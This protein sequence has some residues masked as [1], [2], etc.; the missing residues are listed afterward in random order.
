MCESNVV[1]LFYKAELIVQFETLT[2]LIEVMIARHCLK[3]LYYSY[4][5]KKMLLWKIKGHYLKKYFEHTCHLKYGKI[6][7]IKAKV[8]W[9]LEITSFLFLSLFYQEKHGKYLN[10]HRDKARFFAI[11]LF[12]N[13]KWWFRNTFHSDRLE[14][15][16][17]G[18]GLFFRIPLLFTTL[19][20]FR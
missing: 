19:R 18:F 11:I 13:I 2:P 16:Y 8:A 17:R 1:I 4:L 14:V 20:L 15:D 3:Q 9:T 12:I 6:C 7:V 10:L 5:F